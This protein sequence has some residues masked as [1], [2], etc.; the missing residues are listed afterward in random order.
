MS[1][2][3]IFESGERKQDKGHFRN[4]VLLARADGGVS[5]EEQVLLNRIA[6]RLSLT[7]AQVEDICENPERYPVTPPSGKEER[8]ERFV[9]L[10]EMIALDGEVTSGEQ[11]VIHRIAIALGFTEGNYNELFEKTIKMFKEGKTRTMILEELI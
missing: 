1:I 9:Q 5:E 2:A 3:E 11:K 6:R 7:Q 8:I 4:L 10:C